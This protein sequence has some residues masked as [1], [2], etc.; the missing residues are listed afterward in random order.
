[1]KNS[2][3]HA[4][5]PSARNAI[6][7]TA[8]A[9]ILSSACRVDLEKVTPEELNDAK[10][11]MQ[12]GNEFFAPVIK[13]LAHSAQDDQ[14]L[15]GFGAE[16]GAEAF[17]NS[18]D[19]AIENANRVLE[20]ERLFKFNDPEY[21]D[22]AL[23]FYRDIDRGKTLDLIAVN[24]AYNT[25]VPLENVHDWHFDNPDCGTDSCGNL[26]WGVLAHEGAHE[27]EYH[28]D[29]V[30]KLYGE[31]R[32]DE[33]LAHYDVA[34]LI[35]YVSSDL[36]N[37]FDLRV[38]EPTRYLEVWLMGEVE[39]KEKNPENFERNREN[40]IN[41]LNSLLT[42]EG[43]VEYAVDDDEL[44]FFEERWGVPLEERQ[45]IIAESGWYEIFVEER[46]TEFVSEAKRELGL[47]FVETEPRDIDQEV[48]Q[49]WRE[50]K[51]R[52][53]DGYEHERTKRI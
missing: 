20:N 11:V 28:D 27:D 39:E 7:C 26:T 37:F 46:M 8:T 45:R 40:T 51:Q 4:H 33:V 31:S 48:S 21:Q 44:T 9:A 25:I 53:M 47:E 19:S 2:H 52:E 13:E 49:D 50:Q 32:D 29:G 42:P 10:A 35:S 16:I 1:M 12:E 36:A 24:Y 43:W 18:L 38:A 30:T 3:G 14:Y 6:I 23:A 22:S 5:K 15:Y 34:F 17:C 41:K